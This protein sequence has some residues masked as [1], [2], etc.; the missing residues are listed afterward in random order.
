MRVGLQV[1][2]FLQL[3]T[4]LLNEASPITVP[5]TYVFIAGV[6]KSEEE[7][8]LK[9]G[10]RRAGDRRRSLRERAVRREICFVPWCGRAADE[11]R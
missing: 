11:S 3:L 4:A 9:L 1:P 10:Y 6:S 8:F 5:K 7:H 2:R